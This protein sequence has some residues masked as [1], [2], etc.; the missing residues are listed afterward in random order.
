MTEFYLEAGINHF[1]KKTEATKILNFFLSSKFK[2]LTFMLHTENFYKFQKRRGIDFNLDKKFYQTAIKKCHKKKKR[3]GISVCSLKTLQKIEDLKFDF[4]KLLSISINNLNLIKRIKKKKK[5]VFIS[6]GLKGTDSNIRKC[7][8]HFKPNKKLHLLHTP[9]SY[10]LRE[11]NFMKID[12]LKEKFLLP[13]GYSN[14]NDDKNSI[15]M[16]SSF[17]PSAIFLYC[18]SKSKKKRIYPDDKHAFYFNELEQIIENYAKY[19]KLFQKGKKI[20][21]IK[22]FSNE[23]KF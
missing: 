15:N 12:Y 13:V 18:K 19:S 10:D 16:L 6:L 7:L 1:G 17:K 3:I 4:Y 21:K 22:I 23:Y 11:L 8:E 14:H 2:N 5:P 9:M 20:K